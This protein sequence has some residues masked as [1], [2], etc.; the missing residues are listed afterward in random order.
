MTLRHCQ[1]YIQQLGLGL[2]LCQTIA[3]RKVLFSS[4]VTV[5]KAVTNEAKSE[6]VFSFTEALHA[7]ESM[8]VFIYAHDII[9]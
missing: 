6:P 9:K 3:N 1:T 8:R 7:F 4:L 5:V 2:V